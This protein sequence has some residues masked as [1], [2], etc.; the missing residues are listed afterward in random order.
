MSMFPVNMT[1]ICYQESV[2]RPLKKHRIF[3]E[4]PFTT[5]NEEADFGLIFLSKVRCSTTSFSNA[6]FHYVTVS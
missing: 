4:L 1:Y 2:D 5:E 3:A 6:C